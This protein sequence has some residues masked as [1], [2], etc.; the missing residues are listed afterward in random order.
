M[1]TNYYFKIDAEIKVYG[2]LPINLI[3]EHVDKKDILIHIGKRSAG[4][5]PLFKSNDYYTSVEEL[6]K[7][8]ARNYNSLMIVNEYDEHIT[9]ARL[10]EELID[11]GHPQDR[12]HEDGLYYQDD[13]GYDFTTVDFS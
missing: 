10:K 8:Y 7:F 4:W 11:W 2:E 3:E 9:F 1:S 12:R 13:E 5:S 6:K